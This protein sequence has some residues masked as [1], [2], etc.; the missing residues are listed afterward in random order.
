[1][2][3]KFQCENQFINFKFP[4]FP[5]VMVLG[6][7]VGLIRD[8]TRVCWHGNRSGDLIESIA[9]NIDY[10]L[11]L[12]NVI[13]FTVERKYYSEFK[14]GK[15]DDFDVAYHDIARTLGDWNVIGVLCLGDFALKHFKLFCEAHGINHVH[16]AI[17]HPSHVIRFNENIPEYV[18]RFC[19]EIH[20]MKEF[21]EVN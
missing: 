10:P 17:R 15:F 13:T 16:R 1:M 9:K 18:T 20:R 14:H 12:T 5:C 19:V 7:R 4:L 8:N 3:T 11:I 21:A 2:V 6:E